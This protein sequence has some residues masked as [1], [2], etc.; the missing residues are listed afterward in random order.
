MESKKLFTDKRWT[1][2]PG[3]EVVGYEE[4]TEEEKKWADELI[5]Q[6]EE[7]EKNKK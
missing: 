7:Q 2:D 6:I 1:Q 3:G 4:V 5:K